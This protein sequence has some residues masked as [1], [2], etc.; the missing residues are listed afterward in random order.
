MEREEEGK[1]QNENKK[2]LKKSEVT[3]GDGKKRKNI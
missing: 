2:R 1:C 3:Q